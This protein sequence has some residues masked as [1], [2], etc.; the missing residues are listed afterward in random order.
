MDEDKTLISQTQPYN[1]YTLNVLKS[2]GNSG[3]L[4]IAIGRPSEI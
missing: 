1:R 3:L 4:Q 2:K